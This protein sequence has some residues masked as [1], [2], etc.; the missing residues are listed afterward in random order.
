MRTLV[1]A[2]IILLAILHHDW[3]WWDSKEPLVLGFMP[4]GLAWHAGISL[5][6]GLVGLVAVKF[7]WPEHLDDE[8][9]DAGTPSP[10]DDPGGAEENLAEA[11]KEDAS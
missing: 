11:E 4:I 3:W 1:I 8:E 10:E 5:A 7:C 2:L 9:E 6:A